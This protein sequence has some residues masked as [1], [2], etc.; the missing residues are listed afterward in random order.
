MTCKKTLNKERAEG[1][2]CSLG[3]Y[4]IFVFLDSGDDVLDL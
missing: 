1:I 4:L 2:I 3:T